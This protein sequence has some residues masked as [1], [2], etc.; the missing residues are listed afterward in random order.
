MRLLIVS[1]TV[2]LF[3]TILCGCA[4]PP[5]TVHDVIEI[6]V[7]V[8]ETVP[9]PESLLTPCTVSLPVH[10]AWTNADIEHALAEALVE[11][12]RCTEDKEAIRN[13]E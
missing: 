10:E 12:R 11:L 2:S 6:E 3:A 4:T 5:V 9:V 1:I 7:P 8:I 13:L